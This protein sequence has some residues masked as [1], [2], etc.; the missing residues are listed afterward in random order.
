MGP[1]GPL[2]VSANDLTL[3]DAQKATLATLTAQM[4]P[5]DASKAAFSAMQADLVAG[6][7]AGKIDTAKLQT[8]GT[9][10]DT[11]M[12]AQQAQ[13]ATALNGLYKLLDAGQRKQLVDAVRAKM[14][15]RDQRRGP[16]RGGPPGGGDGGAPD[17]QKRRLDRMT[18][19]LGLDDGQK[20][21]VA[22]LLAKQPAPDPA[23]MKANWDDMKKR[24]DAMLTAFAADGFDATK[25]DWSMPGGKNMKDAMSKRVD[26]LSALIAILK[27]DQLNKL[28]AGMQ[29]GGGAPIRPMNAPIDPAG[30][31]DDGDDD[32]D[33]P[34]PQ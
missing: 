5:S 2:F 16:P 22:A 13:Q 7:K 21:Q 26:F 32:G 12:Q 14:A 11:A 20:T 3:T 31:F 15:N 34:P 10:I 1:A 33:N 27:P 4:G 6:V 19:Q 9:A 30:L 17:M 29:Q 25:L 18:T 28:A 8:D 24:S 23:A